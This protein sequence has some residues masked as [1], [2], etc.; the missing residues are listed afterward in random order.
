MV[1][2]P[3]RGVVVV[4]KEIMM[5]SKCTT[6]LSKKRCFKCHEFGH[7]STNCRGDAKS[8]K[9]SGK[10]SDGRKFD[11]KGSSSSSKGGKSKS[12]GGKKGKMFAVFDDETQSWWKHGSG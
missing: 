3:K 10:P 2:L 1:L 11:G 7:I 9:G 12:K 8:S 6:D 5:V 4:G